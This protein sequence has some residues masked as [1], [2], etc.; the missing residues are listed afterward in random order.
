MYRMLCSDL[1]RLFKS[2]IFYMAVIGYAFVYTAM[3]PLIMWIINF[4]AHT[5]AEYADTELKGQPGTAAIAIAVFV[6]AFILK[7]FTEGSIRN[8]LSSGAK[9]SDIFLSMAVT[10]AVAAFA[11]QAAA[12]ASIVISGKLF[13]AGFL[14][15]GKE[16]LLI[17]LVYVI[18][19]IALAIFDTALMF[20]LGGN[21]ISIFAGTLIA[22]AMKFL[23]IMVLEDL[24]P[25]VG[26]PLVSGTK[27]AV[28][29]FLDKYVPYFH[30]L[31]FPRHGW[32][33]YVIGGAALTVISLIAGIIIFEKKD[34]K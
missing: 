27:L 26:G 22:V 3:L 30:L 29:S 24:Y 32:D 28:F 23:S 1:R 17:N 14:L 34:L 6:T 19:A 12:L 8:K 9:R 13:M 15:S 20:I 33:A 18:A 25:E 21:Q 2:K 31:D 4:F 5:P 16:I 11:I 10:S 7:E